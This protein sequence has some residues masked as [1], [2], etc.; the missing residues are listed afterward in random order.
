MFF[1]ATHSQAVEVFASV[2][3]RA[4]PLWDSGQLGMLITPTIVKL[5]K[6]DKKK[7]LK[8]GTVMPA[9]HS[10][11]CRSSAQCHGLPVLPR[12]GSGA[13]FQS[14]QARSSLP[15]PLA[16]SKAATA[17][18]ASVMQFLGKQGWHL[19]VMGHWL[20]CSLL[21]LWGTVIL[22]P[23]PEFLALLVES[24]QK[25]GLAWSQYFQLYMV[26]GVSVSSST[27][28]HM[29]FT[30]PFCLLLCYHTIPK[31]E[32]HKTALVEVELCPLAAGALWRPSS[33]FVD[34]RGLGTFWGWVREGKGSSSVCNK[35]HW[36]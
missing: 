14:P 26:S 6:I 35:L 11:G 18:V 12:L 22:L 32:D 30:W 31:E 17:S 16:W 21:G 1:Y 23:T 3:S 20:T 19:D 5:Q 13:G 28:K 15:V 9:V 27:W 2:S 29:L 8:W 33:S 36:I 10:L 25:S 4:R 24:D 7:S 34:W